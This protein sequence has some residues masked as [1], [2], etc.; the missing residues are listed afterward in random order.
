MVRR[1]LLIFDPDLPRKVWL[2][3][4]GVLINFLGNGMVAPFLIIYL[5]F[6]RGIPL[7]LAGSAVA[8]GGITAVT[9]GL[10]AGSLSDRLGSRN[11]VVVAM[12]CNAVAYLLYIQVTAPWEAF[13][14]G[15]LVGVGTGAYGPSSQNLLASMVPLEN[16]QAAFAQNRITSVVGLGLGGMIGGILAARGLE[17]YLHLLL[18]DAVTFLTFAVVLL[19][20]PSGRVDSRVETRAS[21]A[22]VLRDRAFIGLVGVNIAMVTAGIAPML[23]L[24]PAFAKGQA[25]VS[26]T[27]IGAIYAANT[28]TI[29]AAQLPLTRLT[30]GRSRMLVLRT[31][32]LIWIASWLIC[33][34][35]GQRLSGNVAALAI[36]FAAVIYAIGECLYSSIM[37]PTA[38]ALAPDN[39]RGRYLGAMGLAWQ[40]G[41]MIGP[42]LGGFVLGTF[43]LGLP[44]LC[45]ALCALA[46]AGMTA[47]DRELPFDL[48]RTPRPVRVSESASRA[49]VTAGAG[50]ENEASTPPGRR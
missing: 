44:I 28:L 45:I 37:L 2:L 49:V 24:L 11:V 4:F 19:K 35:A 39:L 9:S 7:A 3:Q 32:A 6:G 1:L 30:Q 34:A 27:A 23:V 15:F 26:E 22:L 20:L 46:I 43:P 12:V 14:V 25:H 42:S 21:Y 31:G 10:L 50:T 13:A 48:R 40:T 36:G 5:H 41:F 16:R 29:V 33:L 17:G 47:V 38:T 8:L 18:L